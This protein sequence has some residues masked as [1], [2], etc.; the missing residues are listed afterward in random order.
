MKQ[1]IVTIHGGT[2]F[3]NHDDFIA[4]LKNRD[5]TIDNFK[6]R[7]DWKSSLQKNLGDAFEA[8]SPGMPNG[9]NA[10]Y[11]EWKIWFE[12]MIPFLNDSAIL[13][14]HS[15]GGIF[16][17]KYLS[18]NIFPK[19]IRALILVAAP[20]DDSDSDE[21]LGDFTLPPI[22]EKIAAQ[23]KNIYVLHSEDDPVVP[24]AQMRKYTAALPTAHTII[25]KDKK[26]FNQ[27]T[28]PEML[29]L[30]AKI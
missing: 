25:F 11:E 27:E 4:Y 18:E 15:L 23:V 16:L 21:S 26:H 6:P 20:F 13:I 9:G 19:S 28:F 24:F 14:G 1:Q 2:T 29:E 7:T 3:D 12:R 22:L 8:L 30:I 5:V 17:A 10:R